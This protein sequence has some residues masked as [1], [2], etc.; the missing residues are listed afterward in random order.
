MK[1]AASHIALLLSYVS[2]LLLM[3]DYVIASL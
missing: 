2:A 1:S 3:I